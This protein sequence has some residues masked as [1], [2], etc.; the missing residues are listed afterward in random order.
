[1]Y[2]VYRLYKTSAFVDHHTCIQGFLTSGTVELNYASSRLKIQS[3]VEGTFSHIGDAS[4]EK[5]RLF[6]IL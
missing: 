3:Q 6:K 1:M 4:A 2:S 5:A